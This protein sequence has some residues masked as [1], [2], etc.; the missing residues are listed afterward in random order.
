MI[1]LDYLDKRDATNIV[2]IIDCKNRNSW[3][4]T[5]F[6]KKISEDQ[7]HAF[8]IRRIERLAK[9]GLKKVWLSIDGS[10]NDC[11]A[12]QSALAQFGFPKSHNKSKTVVGYMYAVD[13]A[14]GEPVTYSNFP[15]QNA[16]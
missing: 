10:N 11:E 1:I 3:Y 12:R 14:T 8:R 4:S 7:H 16:C 13:A 5:F 6:S 2:C 9:A 15:V